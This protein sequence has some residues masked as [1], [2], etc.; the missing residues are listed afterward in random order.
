MER[1]FFTFRIDI[2]QPIQIPSAIKGKTT[3]CPQFILEDALERGFGDKVNIICTQPRRISALSVA[4][5]VAEELDDAPVGGLVGY[6]IRMESKRTKRTK[7]I[8]CTTGVILRRLVNDMNLEGV[9]H[10]IVDECQ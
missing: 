3:Q 8:Y 9:T 2:F 7:L 10:V 6:S 5:R 4:E 1:Y